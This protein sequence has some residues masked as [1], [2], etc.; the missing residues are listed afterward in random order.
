MCVFDG[1]ENQILGGLHH[2]VVKNESNWE[3]LLLA[4]RY[5][6]QRLRVITN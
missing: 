6:N 1:I 4:P 5:N 2:H 3:V